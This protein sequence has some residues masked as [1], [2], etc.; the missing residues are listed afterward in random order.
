[1]L[2]AET[3]LAG[4]GADAGTRAAGLLEE[5]RQLAGQWTE[6]RKRGL[7]AERLLGFDAAAAERIAAGI[8][9]L[10]GAPPV[11]EGALAGGK[12]R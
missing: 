7:Y 12:G 9:Q 1:M 5:A 4:G 8:E 11:G 2:L 6:R 10:G 3:I